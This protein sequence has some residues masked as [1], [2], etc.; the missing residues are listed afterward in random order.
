MHGID[1]LGDHLL[2][3]GKEQRGR[4]RRRLLVISRQNGISSWLREV[5]SELGALVPDGIGPDEFAE[6]CSEGEFDEA[7]RRLALCK[8]CP[9]HGGACDTNALSTTDPG[10]RP[11]WLDD[12]RRSHTPGLS[13]S[14][15]DKW[16]M[17][18]LRKR[19]A[20]AD[21]GALIDCRFHTYEPQ[22]ETQA[23]A[24]RMCERFVEVFPEVK[25]II[26]KGTI[27]LGKSHLAVATMAE[28]FRQRKA[29]T[30]LFL[31]VGTFF[32]L[33]RR[34]EGSEALLDRAMKADILVFDDVGKQR[35]SEWVREQTDIVINERW[36]HGRS[37]I[38]T[39]NTDAS[40]IAEAFGPAAMSRIEASMAQ[41]VIEGGDYRT[42]R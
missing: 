7:R 28:L 18:Q 8:D 27:G 23:D 4:W 29:R 13:W 40:Q 38:F 11:E 36:V 14:T 22:N 2:Q 41:R 19:L 17:H 31:H 42:K 39:T 25:N 12:R 32:Q 24:V 9:A 34:N 37:T 1:H 21:V 15:C 20:T 5:A 6:A 10:E 33:L 30:G 3:R 26:L 35:T 16:P